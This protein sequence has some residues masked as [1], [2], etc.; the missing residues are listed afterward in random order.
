MPA[1][2]NYYGQQQPHCA[3]I[4]VALA[5]F[6]SFACVVFALP[7]FEMVLTDWE[8]M[9]TTLGLARLPWRAPAGA[10]VHPHA[11][12]TSAGKGVVDPSPRRIVLG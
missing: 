12:L 4:C 2:C 9:M 11:A 10:A 8:S 1:E 3:Y 7:P 5:P 6:D